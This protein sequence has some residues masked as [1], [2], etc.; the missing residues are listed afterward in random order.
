VDLSL[1]ES[2]ES[3]RV[4]KLALPCSRSFNIPGSLLRISKCAEGARI[5]NDPVVRSSG[6]SVVFREVPL[7]FTITKSPCFSARIAVE[8]LGGAWSSHAPPMALGLDE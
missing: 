3:L 5:A 4:V 7:S 8:R 6:T 2:L 1:A